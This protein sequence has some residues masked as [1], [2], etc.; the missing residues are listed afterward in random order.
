MILVD[1]SVL[2]D[3]IEARDQAWRRWSKAALVQAEQAD[4]LCINLMVYAE[5]SHSFEGKAS[6]DQFLQQARIRTDAMNPDIAHMA[7]AAHL[8]YRRAGGLRTATLPDFFIGAHAAVKGFAL[9]TR[10]PTRI[11]ANFPSVRI[12]APPI[13]G[14]QSP[15]TLQ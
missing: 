8:G 12:I 9:L 6:L 1:S 2:I 15:P 5:I 11:R 13:S 10:D 7:A 3:V 4:D 14:E